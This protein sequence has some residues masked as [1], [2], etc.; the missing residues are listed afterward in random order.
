LPVCSAIVRT[1]WSLE[2]FFLLASSEARSVQ[3]VEI[4]SGREDENVICPV[5][6]ANN[7]AGPQCRRCRADVSMLF[8]L[9]ARRAAVLAEACRDAAQGRW[10]EA[11]A[12]AREADAMRRDAD[13]QRLRAVCSLMTGDF[14]AAWSRYRTLARAEA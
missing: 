13:S 8:D 3:L 2:R 5:C 1:F 12:G 4:P 14:A 6:R 7:D 10:R 9:D 11:D